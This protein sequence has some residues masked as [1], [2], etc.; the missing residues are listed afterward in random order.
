MAEATKPYD[1]SW[2]PIPKG[3]GMCPDCDGTGHVPLDEK[4]LT[5]SWYKGYTHKQCT[6]CGG[7]TMGGRALGYT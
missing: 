4:E 7:Q 5:Y 2:Y 1:S 6:N 3:N